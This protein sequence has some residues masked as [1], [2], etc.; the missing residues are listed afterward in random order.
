MHLGNY[1]QGSSFPVI[2]HN[3]HSGEAQKIDRIMEKFGEK[4]VNDNPNEFGSADC[5][6]LL[7]YI[8]LMF[9]TSIHNPSVKQKMKWV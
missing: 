6:Y 3:L 7:G 2:K 4:Y 9:Q 8:L 1:S 5:A